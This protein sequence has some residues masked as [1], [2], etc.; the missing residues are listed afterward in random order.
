VELARRFEEGL[1]VAVNPVTGQQGAILLDLG[2]LGLV[3]RFGGR[4]RD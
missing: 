1:G 4:A 2:E 3:G